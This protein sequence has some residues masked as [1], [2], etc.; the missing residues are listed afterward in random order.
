MIY[1]SIDPIE[2]KS[3]LFVLPMTA[4]ERK[5]IPYLQTPFAKLQAKFSPDSRFVAYASDEP[6]R[7]EIY[8]QTFPESGGKWQISTSGGVQPAWRADGKELYYLAADGKLMAVPVKTAT[9]FEA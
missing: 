3:S 9:S 7:P 6:G 1:S 8:A 5:P 2:Y 4:G